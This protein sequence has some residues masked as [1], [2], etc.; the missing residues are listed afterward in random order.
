ML[1]FT[2][3]GLIFAIPSAL[4][5]LA[6]LSKFGN[7]HESYLFTGILALWHNDMPFL[8]VWTAICG[9][10][11]PILLLGVL[12]GHA[13]PAQ[14][15]W[16]QD[17]RHSLVHAAHA[18]EHWAMPEV[19]ILAVLVSF[20]K[21]GALVNVSAG[22]GLWCYGAMSIS[23]LCAWRSFELEPARDTAIPAGAEVSR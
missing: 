11:T 21:L 22:P 5:P 23:I 14:L 8:S 10:V 7:Q 6:T 2:V 18:L 19:H 3:T 13:L 1:A 17:D 20:V 16:T 12:A 9:V 4:L 15:G